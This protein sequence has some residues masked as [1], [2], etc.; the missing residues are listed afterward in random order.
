M[1]QVV[2]KPAPATYQEW[3]KYGASTL[4]IKKSLLECGKPAPDISFEIY[5]KAFNISRYDELA[6]MNKLEFENICMERAGYKY[7]GTYNTKK[8][9]LLEKYKTLPACQPDARVPMPS[10]EM[11]LNSWYCKTRTDYDYCLKYALAPKFCSP[12]KTKNPPPECLAD[13][14]IHPSD[15]KGIHALEA[16][17]STKYADDLEHHGFMELLFPAFYH[18]SPMSPQSQEYMRRELDQQRL[19]QNIQN[20]NNSQMNQLLRDTTPKIRR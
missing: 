2:Y 10:V 9:C 5:E 4:D 18:P 20:Q 16:E 7:N 17:S 3:S 11:R 14:Q 6:Y 13:N 12:E 19:Q 15:A 1:E 8:I